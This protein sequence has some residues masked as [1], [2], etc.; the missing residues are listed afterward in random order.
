MPDGEWTHPLPDQ[1]H[2]VVGTT[3][4]RLIVYRPAYLNETET[5][6][7]GRVFFVSGAGHDGGSA[8]VSLEA[9]RAAAEATL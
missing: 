1:W 5:D 6:P 3:I 4:A 8:H 7:F 2:Y 9:A